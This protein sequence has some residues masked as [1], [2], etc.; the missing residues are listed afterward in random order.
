MDSIGFSGQNNHANTHKGGTPMKRRDGRIGVRV[1][2]IVALLMGGGTLAVRAATHVSEFEDMGLSP[3]TYWNGSDL[4][5]G[6]HSGWALFRNAYNPEWGSWAGFACSTVSNTNTPSYFN[7]YAV[8]MPGTGRKGSSAYAVVYD[9]AWDEQ[10]VIEFPFP[11]CVQGFYVNN[12]TYAA[13]SMR[14]GDWFSKKFGGETGDDPD[15]FKLTITGKDRNGQTLGS[16]EF[17]LADY[18]FTNNALDYIVSGWTWVDLSS[19]G[20]QVKTLHFTLSSSDNGPWGM[21]TPAYFALDGLTYSPTPAFLTADFENLG[22]APGEYWNGSDQRGGFESDRLMFGNYYNADWH[23]WAGFSLSSVNNTN[24]PGYNN[25]YAVWMPGTGVGGTGTYAVVYDS[26]WDEQDVVTFP[27]PALVK[28]LYVNNTT[29]A[30]LSMRDGDWFSKKF[31]GETG[32]DPDWFKLTITGKDSN[33]QTLKSVEFYLADYRFTNNALDYIVSDWTWVDLSSLGPQVKTL[34]FT[35][36]SSDTGEWG[37]NTPAYFALD[38]IQYIYTFSGPMGGT[39]LYDT[40]VPGFVGP[41]GDGKADAPGYPHPSNYVNRAFAGWAAEVVNYSPAPDVD[42]DWTNA[43][44]TLG[45]VTGDNFDIAS[46]G[47]LN[48]TQMVMGAT[49]GFITLRMSVPIADKEGP[50]FAV[51]ENGF[52]SGG[53]FFGELGYVE[54]SSDGTNFT[55]FPSVSLVTNRVGAYGTF[56][57]RHYYGLCGKHANAYGHSWGTPFDLGDLAWH[58]DVQSGVLNLT[59]VNYVRVV[60]IPG[61]GSFYDTMS[62]PNPIY[63]AW[64]T[65]GSGGLD[66]EAIGVLNSPRHARIRTQVVGPGRINPYGMPE[67]I[68]AVGHGS[69]ETFTMTPDPGYHLVDVWVNGVQQGPVTNYT[70]T[71][72]TEDQTLTAVFGSQLVVVSPHGASVPS[73]GTYYFALRSPVSVS[74]EGSPETV[75]TTQYVCRGW[76]GSGSVP[77]WGTGTVVQFAITND[78]ALVWHWETNYW[79]TATAAGEGSVAA[80]I[81]WHSLGSVVTSTATANPYYEFRGWSGDAQGDTNAPVMVVTMDRPRALVAHFGADLATN[82]VPVSWL[83]AHGLT[84][85]TPDEAALSDRFGKGMKAWEEFYAGTDPNDPNSIFKIVDFGVVN[86][87]NY[88][89]WIGGT[90]GSQRPFTVEVSPSLGGGWTVLTNVTR[91]ASGTNIWWWPASG[92]NRFYRITVNTG[93]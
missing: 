93:P 25:Q 46:L 64:V 92:S 22:L 75:G 26:P 35:L 28:G 7:Q 82:G 29:Y 42:A 47:D 67:G 71:N 78:S 18:R 15:W 54:I 20:P 58:P 4:S 59:N 23:F 39:N 89:V 72:V 6:F 63:D 49:P 84:N 65:W 83:V 81:G 79:L 11:V 88:L 76:T 45:P 32:D 40:P 5:G 3:G 8:W 51:F 61:D 9:S 86:G 24:T 50:D 87:S 34:H 43:A 74:L 80:P 36:S 53:L 14:D 52:I 56:D 30:A 19:L 38:N 70:F 10:D 48:A 57:A 69:N 27:A 17:Y 85:G 13:L 62:P 37:M 68:V 41:H 33:G 55:R 91:A 16:V 73:A 90:N 77:A 31:G 44:K 66:L 21:N 1:G 60:D 12:T 2:A